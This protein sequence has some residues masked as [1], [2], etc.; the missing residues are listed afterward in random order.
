[1]ASSRY[2][3]GQIQKMLYLCVAEHS[4]KTM[5]DNVQIYLQMR[6]QLL[7]TKWSLKGDIM[8]E[9]HREL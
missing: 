8:L 6:E 7:I 5:R 1:M 3:S 4:D 9:T 2:G